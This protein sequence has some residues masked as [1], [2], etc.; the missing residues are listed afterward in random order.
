MDQTLAAYLNS[1]NQ[2]LKHNET[3]APVIRTAKRRLN[4]L[5]FQYGLA[6]R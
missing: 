5:P 4:L 1:P 3:L 6:L 2:A